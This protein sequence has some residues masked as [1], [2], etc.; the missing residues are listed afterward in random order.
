MELTFVGC[1]DAFG[2]G[3]RFNT[4]FHVAGQSTNFLIDCGASSLIALKKL[5]IDPNKIRT[6]LI[7]HFHADHFGGIPFL[8]LDARFFS[9]RTA[10]MTIAGPRGIK[11]VL[12]QY[13][14][15]FFPGSSTIRPGFEL[16]I[17]ELEAGVSGIV[18][19]LSVTPQQVNHGEVGGPYFAYR[20]E[21]DGKVLAYSGDTE[22][23]DTLITA[24]RDADLFIA[25]AYFRDRRVKLHL[26]LESLEQHLD[27]IKPK[28]LIL[29][30][31]SNDMLHRNEWL[32]YEL[33]EDGMTVTV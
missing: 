1:G 11:R 24:G 9:K 13:L 28:R 30:H 17:L 32:D 29:T 6:I 8:L 18:N 12:Q 21:A 22:W 5:R 15:T 16:E 7:T 10:P 14:E 26:D 31:M 27:A 2:S 25:E 20:I 4:C 3:G 33:A 23:T 19:G